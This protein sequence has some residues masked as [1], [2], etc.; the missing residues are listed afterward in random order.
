MP[1]TTTSGGALVNGAPP[2]GEPMKTT[3][4][5]ALRGFYLDGDEIAVGRET[6]APDAVARELIAANKA[7]AVPVPVLADEAIEQPKARRKAATQKE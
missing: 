3:R 4:I 7:V 5:K 2:S 1:M 6:S